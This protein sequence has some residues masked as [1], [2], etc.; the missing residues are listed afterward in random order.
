M[1]PLKFSRDLDNITFQAIHAIHVEVIVKVGT[2]LFQVL[3]YAHPGF[4][5]DEFRHGSAEL[6]ILADQKSCLLEI[7]SLDRIQQG[8][9]DFS[10]IHDIFP[11][12]SVELLLSKWVWVVM[13][14]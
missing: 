8:L 13:E 3:V 11:L 6:T 9:H 2:S 4:A 1:R 10:R 5:L 7:P 14:A 12:L